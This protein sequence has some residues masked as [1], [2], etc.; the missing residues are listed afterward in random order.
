MEPRSSSHPPNWIIII[1]TSWLIS[2]RF[3]GGLGTP[4]PERTGPRVSL[5]NP[6][7]TSVES[8]PSNAP[9]NGF[10]EISTVGIRG[11]TYRLFRHREFRSRV[12]FRYFLLGWHL[13]DTAAP[14]IR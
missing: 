4:M 3:S 9:A 11:I 5:M 14:A 7:S 12:V 8:Y 13:S 6:N 1:D 10:P 2:C